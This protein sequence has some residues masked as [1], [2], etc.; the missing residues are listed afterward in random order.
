MYLSQCDEINGCGKTYPSDLD[1]CPHCKVPNAF[2]SPALV[3]ERDYEYDIETYPNIF[4]CGITHIATGMR[5]SFEISDRMNQID[6]FVHFIH[7]LRAV[8]ARMVGYNN[9]GFD[10]PVIHHIVLNPWV[11]HVEIYNKAM[12]II[13]FT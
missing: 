7:Q 8:N 13:N 3:D 12:S 9:V 11:T 1:S 2:A 10:Y 5:W 6:E 4:T